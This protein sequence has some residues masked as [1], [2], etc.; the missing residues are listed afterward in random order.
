MSLK[1]RERIEVYRELDDPE[2]VSEG[3]D[4]PIEHEDGW[5]EELEV[6]NFLNVTN[7]RRLQFRGGN[8]T[9][10]EFDGDLEIQCGGGGPTP[11]FITDWVAEELWHELG[12]E[13]DQLESHGIE[14]VDIE[15]D[16]VHRL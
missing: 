12:V 8:P 3:A 1:H 5:V 2:D 15:R 6:W 4:G 7:I 16:E 11:D 10:E 14:V 13:D 9:M